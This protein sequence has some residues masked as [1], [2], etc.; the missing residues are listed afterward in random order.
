MSQIFEL[1]SFLYPIQMMQTSAGF[2]RLPE[3]IQ[4]EIW[5]TIFADSLFCI[6]T[7]S[8]TYDALN[9]RIY[10]VHLKPANL[11]GG[12]AIFPKHYIHPLQVLHPW[13]SYY[14]EEGMYF[15]DEPFF[16]PGEISFSEYIDMMV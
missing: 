9:A 2:L 3:D 4:R 1:K 7:L 15:H 11:G 12:W 5:K 13:I 10:C 16:Y 14:E 6:Q 8:T